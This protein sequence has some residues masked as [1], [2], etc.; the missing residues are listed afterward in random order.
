VYGKLMPAADS[1]AM[2][3]LPLGLAHKVKLFRPVAAG[4]ALRW[5]DVAFDANDVAVK[6]RREMETM[7]LGESP[8]VRAA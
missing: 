3:G 1:L 4:T 8:T 5:Q 6:V 7:F 2:G